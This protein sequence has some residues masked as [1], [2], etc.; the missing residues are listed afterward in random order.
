M[1]PLQNKQVMGRG[2]KGV[3]SVRKGA[4]AGVRGTADSGLPAATP[5]VAAVTAIVAQPT[6]L[7]IDMTNPDDPMGAVVD[8]A[9]GASWTTPSPGPALRRFPEFVLRSQRVVYLLVT[10]DYRHSYI[11][12]TKFLE[13]RLRQHNMEITGG[14][15]ATSL[16]VKQG[17]R[18]I[19]ALHMKGFSTDAA[20]YNFE[21]KW[22]QVNKK[23]SKKLPLIEQKMQGLRQLVAACGEHCVPVWGGYIDL[24]WEDDHAIEFG[25]DGNV[26]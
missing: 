14:A 24:T 20:A 23:Q 2:A 12:S 16:K 26:L 21:S 8:A 17:R 3:R 18:W 25:A 7:Y 10:D 11:G 6:R 15:W 5:E 13:R 22:K 9:V 1:P 19:R 4:T